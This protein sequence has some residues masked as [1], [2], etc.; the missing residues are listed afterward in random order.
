M[1]KESGAQF[2]ILGHSERRQLFHETDNTVHAKIKQALTHHLQPLVC[3]GETLEQHKNNETEAVLT[4]QI[5]GAFEGIPVKDFSEVIL[6]YE[7]VWAIGTGLAA[8]I[9]QISAV[10]TFCRQQITRVL[11]REAASK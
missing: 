1:V 2:V 5:K 3:V 4:E 9:D 7:P 8:T 6:A 11:G 10:H